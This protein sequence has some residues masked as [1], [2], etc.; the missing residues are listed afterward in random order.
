MPCVG[1]GREDPLR[2][3][4]LGEHAALAQDGDAVAH[5]DRLVDVVG[6]EDDGLAQLAVQA[7]RRGR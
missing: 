2:R 3:V 4:V 6:D 7:H 5:L 1:G